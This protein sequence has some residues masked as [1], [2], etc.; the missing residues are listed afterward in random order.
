MI[1]SCYPFFESLPPF[2]EPPP[3]YFS[4]LTHYFTLLPKKIG[5]S[6][7]KVQRNVIKRR[8]TRRCLDGDRKSLLTP[9]LHF[10]FS[11]KLPIYSVLF[12]HPHYPQMTEVHKQRCRDRVISDF[13]SRSRHFLVFLLFHDVTSLHFREMIFPLV[14]LY[15][16]VCALQDQNVIQ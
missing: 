15:T 16:T 14:M 3:P 6:N 7:Y 10:C 12:I 2:L 8:G 11:K 4:S 13:L 5:L 1:F 9:S